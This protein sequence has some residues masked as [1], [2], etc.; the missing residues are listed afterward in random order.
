[1][2]RTFIHA[3]V[4]ALGVVLGAWVALLGTAL[5][6]GLVAALIAFSFA[7]LMLTIAFALLSINAP[8]LW[9][10][11]ICAAYALFQGLNAAH[12]VATLGGLF[13]KR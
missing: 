1:M 5:V 7:W 11:T 9:K 2:V 4:T 6:A 3:F 10:D 8:P 12:S 13:G